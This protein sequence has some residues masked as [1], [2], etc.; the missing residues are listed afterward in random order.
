MVSQ[1]IYGN[2]AVAF[3]DVLGFQNKLKEFENEAVQFYAEF[4]VDNSEGN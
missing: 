1:Y 4:I 2:R 3:L